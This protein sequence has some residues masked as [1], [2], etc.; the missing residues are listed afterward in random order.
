MLDTRQQ[1][2]G[3]VRGDEVALAGRHVRHQRLEADGIYV[4]QLRAARQQ[5]A[6]QA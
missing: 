4:P 5:L 6:R 3:G 2:L 1:R